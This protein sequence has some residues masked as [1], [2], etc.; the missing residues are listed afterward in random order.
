MAILTDAS[1]DAFPNGILWPLFPAATRLSDYPFIYNY[2]GLSIDFGVTALLLVLFARG[3]L[4]YHRC[5]DCS[6]L[7]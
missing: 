7:R 4:G 5:R 2:L 3:R 1:M 6:A